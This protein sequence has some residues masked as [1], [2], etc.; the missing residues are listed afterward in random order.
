[1]RFSGATQA[2]PAVAPGTQDRWSWI[3][4][5]AA[6]AEAA[7][8]APAVRGHDPSAEARHAPRRRIPVG[9]A[10]AFEVAGL[11][12]ELERWVVPTCVPDTAILPDGA[13]GR[14]A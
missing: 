10:W 5:L 13:A 7:S 9:T 11:R 8:T 3:A 12:G 6:I 2:L 1:M 14:D 4:Q